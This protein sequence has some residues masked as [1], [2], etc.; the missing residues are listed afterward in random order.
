MVEDEQI[1][2]L[3][4]V[5][6][7]SRMGHEVPAA[8]ASAEEA[9]EAAERLRPD[10]VL[11]DIKLRGK[12]D[13]IDAAESIRRRFDIPVV[14]LTA[15]ADDRTLERAKT[16]E[17]FGYILKPFQERELH[18][19]IEVALHRHR[20]ARRL[21]EAEAWRAAVLRSAGDAVLAVGPDGRIRLMN[22]LAE[23]LTGWHEND[24][25][26]LPLERVFRVIECPERRRP[27]WREASYR[28]LVAKDGTERPVDV[29]SAAIRD[30]E[31]HTWG[32]V[33]VFRDVSERKRLMDR[34]RFIAFAG[35]ELSSSLEREALVSKAVRLIARCAADWCAVHLLDEESGQL[36][37]AGYA[38]ARTKMADLGAQLVDAAPLT[39]DPEGCIAR[40]ARLSVSS[41]E[42]AISQ[43]LEMSGTDGE[44]ARARLTADSLMCAPLVAR[45]RSLG[46]LVLV[47]ERS[48]RRFTEHDLPFA[49]ELGRLLATAVDNAHLYAA[50]QRAIRLR[51]DVLSIVSHDLRSPLVN[52]SL[53]AEQVLRARGSLSPER[54]LRNAQ[55]ILRN[56]DRMTHLIGDL[57]DVGR[58]DSGRLSLERRP[59]RAC[60]I[61]TE[62]AALF[63][64]Q[65]AERS[66]TLRVA[67]VLPD[68][69][70]LCD[71][72]R[73][74]QVF[75][76]LIDNA[77]KLSAERKV[78]RLRGTVEGPA[79]EFHVSDE[80]GGIAP[81]QVGR[82]FDQYWQAPH[83]ARKGTGLGLY[84]A[85]G[86]VEAHGGQISVD[87]RPGAGS[88]F[89]FTIPLAPPGE[90]SPAAP[91]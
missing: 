86:I 19:V 2:A 28:K 52:I 64:A 91:R 50:A 65:A 29:E 74:L 40:A 21:M 77:L 24:A 48:D 62:A 5:E 10:L 41:L 85:K 14:Y 31:D 45:G 51:D 83:T 9:I 53:N 57:V 58:I 23:A 76:N 39:H 18:V 49:E 75:S 27:P 55:L 79:V 17:P 47:S 15:F 3:D 89:C 38:H 70:I 7:L 72:D 33:W 34:Q 8:V 78:I 25:I 67:S 35:R 42:G 54:A 26:G 84:I 88:D 61:V 43:V 6:R 56:A 59:C 16:T 22:A 69:E 60:D 71:R 11:M 12:M 66:I 68:V 81:D 90:D 4:L 63:E 46:A 30:S 87:T 80:A 73:V 20:I 1:V 36:R 13:G 37:I 44:L 32:V 82:I